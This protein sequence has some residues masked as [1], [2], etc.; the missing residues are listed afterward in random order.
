MK[1]MALEPDL[2]AAPLLPGLSQADDIVSP[3]EEQVL[4]AAIDATALGAIPLSSM[5]RQATHRLL[6]LALRF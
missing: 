1:A 2:F 3:E 4:I 5:G 6:W